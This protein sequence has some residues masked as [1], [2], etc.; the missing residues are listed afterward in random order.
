M[1]QASGNHVPDSEVYALLEVEKTSGH[2][3]ADFL[4][5]KTSWQPLRP[6]IRWSFGL[7]R[8]VYTGIVCMTA[9]Q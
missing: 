7:P 8:W 2:S 6:V 5:Q 3:V 9:A 1:E 4:L